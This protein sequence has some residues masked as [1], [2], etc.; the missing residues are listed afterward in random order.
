MLGLRHGFAGGREAGFPST[1]WESRNENLVM[2][3]F[4]DLAKM[5][6]QKQDIIELADFYA[7]EEAVFDGFE[8]VIVRP[9][10]L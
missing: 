10:D 3:N 1:L 2:N 5:T 8:M 4:D 7:F 6:V 9:E